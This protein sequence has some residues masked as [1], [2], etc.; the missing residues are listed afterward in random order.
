M[1]CQT[2][3]KRKGTLGRTGVKDKC[4]F[5]CFEMVDH[6]ELKDSIISIFTHLGR[7]YPSNKKTSNQ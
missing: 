2:G 6:Q 4:W 5:F 3:S 7:W 1:K